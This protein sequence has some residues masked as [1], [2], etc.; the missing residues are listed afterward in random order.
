MKRRLT[1]LSLIPAILLLAGCRVHEVPEGGDDGAVVELS[2]RVKID[3][4]LTQYKD[5]PYEVK[6]D[7]AYQARYVVGLFRYASETPNAKPDYVFLFTED[8]MESRTLQVDVAPMNYKVLVWADY[9]QGDEVFY[10]SP[11]FLQDLS[12]EKFTDV[13][14]Q[15]PYAGN[16]PWRD[17]FYGAQDVKLAGYMANRS[18]H[19]EEINLERPNAHFNFV[20]TDMEQFASYM[21][22][23][24]SGS[25]SVDDFQVKLSYPQFLPCT[26]NLFTDKPVDSCTGVEFSV[27]PV[28]LQDGSVDLGG[29]WVFAN[30]DKT[31]VIV[32]LSFYDARGQ[33]I[34]SL[35]NI[36]VPLCRG[37]NT[38][39]KGALLTS[40]VSS[41]I[42]IDPSFD[43]EF[44]IEL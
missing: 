33:F 22:S 16:S 6:A 34:S 5:I 28:M 13:T 11:I 32:T 42:S 39:I 43:G 30:A 17:A 21:A 36:E 15:E 24:S 12:K 3:P 35:N 27:T 4:S 2:L 40:G 9:V 18:Q 26:Y 8:A 41:G 25:F 14:L 1:I 10:T 38:T 23:K 7:D 29:D 31:S 20:A 37:K 19:T 44:V